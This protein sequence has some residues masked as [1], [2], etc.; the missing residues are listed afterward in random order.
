[1]WFSFVIFENLPAYI[2][3]YRLNI[4][5]SQENKNINVCNSSLKIKKLRY[6]FYFIL[7]MLF[8]L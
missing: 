3:D 6:L 5:D 1:M 2:N 7:K 8:L 4:I